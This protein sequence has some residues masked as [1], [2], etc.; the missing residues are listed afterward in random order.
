MVWDSCSVSCLE[1]TKAHIRFEPGATVCAGRSEFEHPGEIDAYVREF[2]G[3]QS[4]DVDARQSMRRTGKYAKV[5]SAGSPVPT[6]GDPILDLITDDTGSLIIAGRKIALFTESWRRGLHRMGGI[7]GIDY[8]IDKVDFLVKDNESGGESGPKVAQLMMSGGFGASQSWYSKQAT[9]KFSAWK[10]DYW[11]YWS[12]GAEIETW[13]RDFTYAR[14]DS[15]YAL[16]LGPFCLP[17]FHDNDDD[18]DDDY[19]DEWEWGFTIISTN[20]ARFGPLDRVTSE[21]FA[22]W[23]GGEYRGVVA[24]GEPCGGYHW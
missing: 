23:S 16:D 12:M 22:R 1:G 17:L 21:C 13:G 18:T 24:A 20:G 3:L 7:S 9:L 10:S 5:D 19:V 4:F 2:F 15:E 11:F 8:A 14:I 6:F